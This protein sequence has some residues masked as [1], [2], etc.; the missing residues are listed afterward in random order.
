MVVR[1]LDERVR[2]VVELVNL[3]QG[4]NT[5]EVFVRYVEVQRSLGVERVV[6]EAVDKAVDLT[7]ELIR[8]ICVRAHDF[9]FVVREGADEVRESSLDT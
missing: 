3:A 6:V 4:E 9:W 7:H 8:V 2:T 1:D 5:T